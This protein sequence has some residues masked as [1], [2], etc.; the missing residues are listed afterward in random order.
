MFTENF[1]HKGVSPCGNQDIVP[2]MAET[3][4]STTKKNFPLN[5][6]LIFPLSFLPTSTMQERSWRLGQWKGSIAISVIKNKKEKWPLEEAKAN[7][8]ARSAK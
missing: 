3:E 8:I 1:L 2:A 7:E 6:A 5:D 4:L